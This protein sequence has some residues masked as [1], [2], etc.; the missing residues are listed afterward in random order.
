MTP[1]HLIATRVATPDD[2][3]ESEPVL[4]E[5]AEADVD[6]VRLVLDDGAV[7]DFDRRELLNA[8]RAA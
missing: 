8:V 6:V 5:A 3:P 4:V 1:T 7:L 2:A